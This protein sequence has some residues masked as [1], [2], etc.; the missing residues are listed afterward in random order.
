M[1]FNVDEGMFFDIS[2]HNT[3]LNVE[4]ESD[5]FGVLAK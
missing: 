4:L 3:K 5:D 1:S 2:R